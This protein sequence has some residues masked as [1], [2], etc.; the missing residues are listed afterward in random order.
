M[1]NMRKLDKILVVDLEATCWSGDAPKGVSEIIEIGVAVLDHHAGVV[2]DAAG[3]LVKPNESEISPFCTELTTITKEM[4]EQKGYH[5]PEAVDRLRDLYQS[6]RRPW[7]S[8][9]DFDRTMVQRQCA[10]RGVTYPFSVRHLNVKNLF[11]LKYRLESGVRHAPGPADAGASS[12]G[13]APSWS[14]RRQEHRPD[15]AQP[16]QTGMI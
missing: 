10:D 13:H 16:H 2:D 11:A 4:V 14:G 1:S 6:D 12:R 9:G 7:A 8:W 5:F 15:S 3:I